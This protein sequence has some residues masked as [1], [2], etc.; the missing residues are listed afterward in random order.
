M[1]EFEKSLRRPFFYDMLMDHN[2]IYFSLSQ[3]NALCRGSLINDQIEI[4]DTFPNMSTY[5]WRRCVG[6]C[7]LKERLL[8][9]SSEKNDNILMYD[10]SNGKFSEIINNKK[11]YFYSYH[12]FEYKDDLYIVSSDTAEIFK[13]ESEKLITRNFD[14]HQN[15]LQD[16]EIE[17]PI[18]VENRIYI[19]VNKKR[20]LLVFDLEKEVYESFPFPHI[21]S[22]ICTMCYHS[23]RLFIAGFD[24]MVYAWNIYD[25]KV[26]VIASVPDHV[27]LYYSVE[28]YFSHS[29]IYNNVLFLF[30]GFADAILMVDIFTGQVETLEIS[31][32][33]ESAEKIDWELRHGRFFPVKYNIVQ[34]QGRR[35]FFRSSKTRLL[36]ELDL[37]TNEIIKHDFK[38]RN[39][40]QNQIYPPAENGILIENYYMDG[41]RI[42]MENLGE[43]IT[44]IRELQGQNVGRKIYKTLDG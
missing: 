30:P 37:Q 43:K 3:Y 23:G 4:I 35:V 11:I 19:S 7:K 38:I 26:D 5:E 22:R 44:D 20:E 41:V 16:A 13:I 39:I 18:R 42:L 15:I 33:E 17:I 25:G 27:K 14:N 8:F 34:K 36:Y 40:Y 12:A 31:G 10:L 1:E 21:I 9:S 6:V 24:R 29:L 2:D 28:V 32:E